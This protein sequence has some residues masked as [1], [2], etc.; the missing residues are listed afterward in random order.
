MVPKIGFTCSYTPVPLIEAA[1]FSPYRI[2]PDTDSADQAGHLLHDNLCPHVKK[3]LDRCLDNDL[4]DISGMIFINSCDT[5]RRLSDAWHDT[6]PSDRITLIE[7]PSSTSNSSI[8]YLAEEYERMARNL[9]EWNG[10]AFSLDCIHENIELWNQLA[11]LVS[12]IEARMSKA[13]YPGLAASFQKVINAAAAQSIETALNMAKEILSVEQTPQKGK[14]KVMVFG[15]LLF[16]PKVF[17]LLEDWNIHVAVNDFC[18]GSRF[19]TGIDTGLNDNFFKALASSYLHNTPCART[20]DT[21]TPGN[22]AA[23]IVEKA[24]SADVKGVIGFTLKF[25]DPYLA[26]VPMIREALANESIPFLMLEGDCT[27][28]AMGQQQTRIE[29]FSEILGV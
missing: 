1:G 14:A 17:D 26:R 18:T 8:D 29:A 23:N 20:M 24:K 13:F 9:F 22:I 7:L 6:R 10:Q 27:M 19:I 28:G 2:F 21:S 3:V 25:C 15:N 16:D 4:D 11:V 5:M 12:E